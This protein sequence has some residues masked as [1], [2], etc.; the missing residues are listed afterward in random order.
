MLGNSISQIYIEK[1]NNISR[2][3]ELAHEEEISFQT[4]HVFNQFCK[5]IINLNP[6]NTVVNEIFDFIENSSYGRK[7]LLFNVNKYSIETF[8]ELACKG[9]NF[10]FMNRF[11]HLE[12]FVEEFNKVDANVVF[13]IINKNDE[14]FLRK[15]FELGADL[16]RANK[17][18]TTLIAHMLQTNKTEI[19][20]H[21]FEQ[22]ENRVDL[23][24]LDSDRRSLL[25]YAIIG[26]NPAMIQFLIEQGLNP[27]QK[28]LYGFTPLDYALFSGKL[29][30]AQ[31]LS[32]QSE[33]ELIA[34]P[35]YQHIPPTIDHNKLCEKMLKYLEIKHPGQDLRKKIY[36][37]GPGVC[38]GWSPLAALYTSISEDDGERF[39]KIIDLMCKWDETAKSLQEIPSEFKDEFDSLDALFFQMTNDIVWFHQQD[40]DVLAVSSSDREKQLE[41]ISDKY[42]VKRIADFGLPDMTDQETALIL[43]KYRSIAD[44]SIIDVFSVEPSGGHTT[45]YYQKHKNEILYFD[46]NKKHKMVSFSTYHDSLEKTKGFRGKFRALTYYHSSPQELTS[47]ITKQADEITNELIAE[48]ILKHD[49]ISQLKEIIPYTGLK[50]LSYMLNALFNFPE[51]REK[52]TDEIL[53][54]LISNAYSQARF[55]CFYTLYQHGIDV[56]TLNLAPQVLG[57]FL[58]TAIQYEDQA[59]FA[60][61]KIALQKQLHNKI[62]LPTVDQRNMLLFN[63]PKENMN[64]SVKETVNANCKTLKCSM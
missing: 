24:V 22:Y 29:A 6:S 3:L 61:M 55:E 51:I 10:K 30:V 9:N 57:A 56:N 50:G 14:Q 27:A 26:D 7:L 35:R 28:D 2:N 37:I 20:N 64:N 17:E 53:K 11:I 63:F 62:L 21:L 60:T 39:Y 58:K 45:S 41:L 12:N 31:I 48:L 8:L 40:H 36:Q 33:G 4:L 54:N 47:Q 46:P 13:E 1:F 32:T 49:R 25:Y 44:K 23:T 16:N 5:E 43:D 59:M 18:G 38:H 52:I 19:L 42:R 34:D 15:I